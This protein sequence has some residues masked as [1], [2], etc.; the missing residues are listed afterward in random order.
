M[1]TNIAD[2]LGS[3]LL[4]LFAYIGP[5]ADLSLISS[6]IGLLLTMGS[7]AVFLALWPLRSLW[8][9]FRNGQVGESADK[10]NG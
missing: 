7:S 10:V 5:G 2:L 4:S 1:L 9:R 3:Q 8:R 6:V